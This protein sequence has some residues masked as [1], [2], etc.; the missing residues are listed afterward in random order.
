MRKEQATGRTHPGPHHP[1]SRKVAQ[2][3]PW[4]PPSL[5]GT[6]DL[7]G[8]KTESPTP[9]ARSRTGLKAQVELVQVGLPRHHGDRHRGLGTHASHSAQ[10][11]EQTFTISKDVGSGNLAAKFNIK[12]CHFQ[13]IDRGF[14]G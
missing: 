3:I 6:L 9:G 7:R 1:H 8:P 13:F 2:N 12:E 14:L 11:P 4:P 10:C 5:I